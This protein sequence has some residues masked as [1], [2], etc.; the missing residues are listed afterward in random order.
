MSRSEAVA[1]AV[2]AKPAAKLTAF[3]PRAHTRYHI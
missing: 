1:P 3:T 2:T